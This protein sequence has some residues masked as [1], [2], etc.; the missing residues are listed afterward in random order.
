MQISYCTII[1][2]SF[3]GERMSSWIQVEKISFLQR[4]DGLSLNSMVRS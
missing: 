1:A 4:A 3:K 2:S